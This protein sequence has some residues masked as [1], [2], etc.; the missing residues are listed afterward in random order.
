[1]L[2]RM[3][4][5][6]FACSTSIGTSG[7]QSIFITWV[8]AL[9]ILLHCG[10]IYT[11][12]WPFKLFFKHA[13]QWHRVHSQSGMT[14]TVISFQNFFFIPNRNSMLNTTSFSPRLAFLDSFIAI[15]GLGGKSVLCNLFFFLI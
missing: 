7:I 6:C 9:K 2:V 8:S 13:I 1:M 10:K 11:L 3:A 12:N 14:V 4:N 15:L 5:L